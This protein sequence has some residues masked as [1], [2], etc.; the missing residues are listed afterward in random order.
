MYF[1]CLFR[2]IIS[3]D[4]HVFDLLGFRQRDELF[5]RCIRKYSSCSSHHKIQLGEYRVYFQSQYQTQH[6]HIQLETNLHCCVTVWHLTVSKLK[7]STSSD[8]S[9]MSIY[10]AGVEDATTTSSRLM[11]ETANEINFFT[12]PSLAVLY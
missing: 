4:V 1:T 8:V 11:N 2:F 3:F 6:R 9:L 7:I 5:G 12:F 10:G